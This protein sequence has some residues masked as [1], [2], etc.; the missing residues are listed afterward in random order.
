MY[1]CNIQTVFFFGS[2]CA[3]IVDVTKW[4]QMKKK[5]MVETVCLLK[6]CFPPSFF[7]IMIPLTIH[8]IH[9]IRLYGLVYLRWMYPFERNLKTL[10]GYVCNRNCLEGCIEESHIVEEAFEFYADYLS[11]M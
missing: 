11:N 7:D 5:H 8:V 2:I 10:K 6:K 1:L 4:D 9:K 3:T